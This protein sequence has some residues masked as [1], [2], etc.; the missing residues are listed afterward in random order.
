MKDSEE[1]HNSKI[2]REQAEHNQNNG[3]R[4]QKANTKLVGGHATT[5]LSSGSWREIKNQGKAYM[6]YHPMKERSSEVAP[7]ANVPR[8][9]SALK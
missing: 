1:E 6:R 2:K 3:F 4:E 7:D 9:D 8:A 5:A